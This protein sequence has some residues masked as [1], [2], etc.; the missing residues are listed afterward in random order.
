[1]VSANRRFL[2]IPA[3]NEQPRLGDVLRGVQRTGIDLEALVVDDG[4]ADRTAEV[5]EHAGARVLR[6]PFNL[7]YAA[8]LQTGYKYAYRHKASTVAQMD[9]DGQHDPADLPRLIEAVETGA[10][11][12]AIGSRFLES[13]SYR[14]G[15]ARSAGR[16]LLRAVAGGMGLRVTDPTSGFQAMNRRTLGIYIDDVFPTDYADLDVLLLARRCGIRIVEQ[17][18]TM[19]P[20]PRS[21]SI[22][23][24]IS[25]IYYLYRIAL[26]IWAGAAGFRHSPDT[27]PNNDDG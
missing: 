6:H 14:M 1:M 21:S 24:G 10:A 7:G 4:S 2:V 12:L 9:A 25:P 20:S 19:T 17:P 22:H 16:Y 5:A 27:Q 3:R 8:A 15:P 23:G 11:D 18:V 13:G 26:S